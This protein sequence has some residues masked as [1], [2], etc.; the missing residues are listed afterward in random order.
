MISLFVHF[1]FSSNNFLMCSTLL[2]GKTK[3]KIFNKYI[4][5]KLFLFLS[6]IVIN[7]ITSNKLVLVKQKEQN[8]AKSFSYVPIK[9]TN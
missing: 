2:G 6:L 7:I 5:K 3:V 1:V 9:N 4:Y 8:T